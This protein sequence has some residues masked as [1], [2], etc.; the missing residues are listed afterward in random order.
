MTATQA[1]ITLVI[2]AVVICIIYI[3]ADYL[4]KRGT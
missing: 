2:A 4:T 3:V 1:G